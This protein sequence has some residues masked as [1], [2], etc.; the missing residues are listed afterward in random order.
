MKPLFEYSMDKDLCEISILS[1]GKTSVRPKYEISAVNALENG[2]A[3]AKILLADEISE[4]HV[5]C[6]L[7]QENNI[8]DEL[9]QSIKDVG[10]K[11]DKYLLDGELS[12]PSIKEG[13]PFSPGM[14][15]VVNKAISLSLPK[16]V[17]D[18]SHLLKALLLSDTEE[19]RCFCKKHNISDEQI[20]DIEL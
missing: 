20:S 3:I 9:N 14:K 11:I 13:L 17:V 2:G 15:E 16:G 5:L 12:L 4:Y 6:A 8:N 19:M 7:V 18:P 10:L 1:Y